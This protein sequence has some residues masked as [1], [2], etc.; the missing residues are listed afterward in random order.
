MKKILYTAFIYILLSSRVLAA[1]FPNLLP[2]QLQEIFANGISL[3][4][5]IVT[6]TFAGLF[7]WAGYLWMTAYDNDE[8]V[9]KARAILLSAITG[10]LLIFLARP[11]LE[12]FQSIFIVQAPTLE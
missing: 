12:F 3:V 9:T 10:L 6:L 1:P 7:F 8:K 2:I 5:A 4:P 11:L